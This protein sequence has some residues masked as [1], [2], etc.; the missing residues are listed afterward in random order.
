MKF[1]NKEISADELDRLLN[2]K[3]KELE[4]ANAARQEISA[5][6]DK[7]IDISLALDKWKSHCRRRYAEIREIAEQID[8]PKPWKDFWVG[9]ETRADDYWF[10]SLEAANGLIDRYID[11]LSDCVL[12]AATWRWEMKEAERGLCTSITTADRQKA[13]EHVLYTK[14]KLKEKMEFKEMNSYPLFTDPE[15]VRDYFH[16]AIALFVARDLTTSQKSFFGE[17]YGETISNLSKCEFTTCGDVDK[18]FQDISTWSNMIVTQANI[19]KIAFNEELV[20]LRVYNGEESF[21]DI[22]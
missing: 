1:K 9:A 19:E 3:K 20:L 12:E 6:Q 16:T 4:K 5:L 14:D 10:D 13:N 15:H 2:S 7:P 21:L 22:I 8:I 11:T 17:R 18:V